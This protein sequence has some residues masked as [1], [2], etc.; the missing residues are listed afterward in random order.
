MLPI[1]K[2]V[3]VKGPLGTFFSL[4]TSYNSTRRL[5]L[6]AES[7]LIEDG[8]YMYGRTVRVTT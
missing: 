1:P 8:P 3:I 6:H 5:T 2:P 4:S 7:P